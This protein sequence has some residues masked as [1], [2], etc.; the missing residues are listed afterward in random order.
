[1][2]CRFLEVKVSHDF[3]EWID[4]TLLDFRKLDVELLIDEFA[5]LEEPMEV[6][7]VAA[8]A[9]LF[10]GELEE[11]GSER[12]IV[13]RDPMQKFKLLIIRSI[14]RSR[15]PKIRTRVGVVKSQWNQNRSGFCQPSSCSVMKAKKPLNP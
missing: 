6:S 10:V 12:R 5:S 8:A 4:D 15:F 9:V 13:P 14:S 1:L 2:I 7:E 11:I 3:I